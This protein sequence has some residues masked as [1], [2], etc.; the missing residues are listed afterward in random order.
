[1]VKSHVMVYLCDTV[2]WTCA[3]NRNSK[4]SDSTTKSL[5]STC[6]WFCKN[7]QTLWASVDVNADQ[8]VPLKTVLCFP[9][10]SQMKH[11]VF[12]FDVDSTYSCLSGIIRKNDCELFILIIFT[13]KKIHKNNVVFWILGCTQINTVAAYDSV[14]LILADAPWKH[15]CYCI[16][17]SQQKR[18]SVLKLDK[19]G[20][21]EACCT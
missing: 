16:K 10:C 21:Q 4:R 12:G 17:R 11:E 7:R 9:K 8:T 1:M 3:H 14:V 15:F 20:L 18:Q 19:R 13:K 2:W 6:L 5:C